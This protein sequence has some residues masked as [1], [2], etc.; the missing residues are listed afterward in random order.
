[1]TISINTDKEQRE[2]VQGLIEANDGYC[3]CALKKDDNIS[4]ASLNCPESL[5]FLFSIS[6]C[7][8]YSG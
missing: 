3:I 2:R 6:S 7:F 8:L 5:L 1:M 4:I